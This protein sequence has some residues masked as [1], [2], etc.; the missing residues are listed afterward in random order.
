[1]SNR[2]TVVTPSYNQARFLDETLASVIAQRDEIHEYF[3]FDGGSTDGSQDVIRKYESRIDHWVS[4]KD[5]GQSDAISKGFAR[6]TGDILYWINS[7]DVLLPGAIKKVRTLF[8]DNPD[9]GAITGWQVFI[10]GDSRV[11]SCTRM[12][13]ESYQ[14]ASWGVTHISQPSTFFKRELFNKIGGLN[15]GLHCVMDTELWYRMLDTKQP[16]TSAEMYVAGFRR[17]EDAKGHATGSWAQRYHKEQEE[18]KKQ[19]PHFSSNT[20]SPFGRLWHQ[21]SQIFSGK[22]I[23]ANADTKRYKGKPWQEA[24]GFVPPEI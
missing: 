8:A 16:W 1:M 11:M 2:I 7:D 13:G 19:F 23:A 21:A 15:L 9:L 22:R 14:L 17:H 6:A 5:K 12:P 24:F 4:E 18:L 10:D 20:K 3:V